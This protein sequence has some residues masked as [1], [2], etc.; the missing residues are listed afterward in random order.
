MNAKHILTI[1]VD[2]KKSR[3][4]VATV[5]KTYSYFYKPFNHIATVKSGGKFVKLFALLYSLPLFLYYMFN[6]G[7]RIVHVHGASNASFWR[8]AFFILVAKCFKKKVVYHIHGGGFK[9]FSQRNRSLVQFV[10]NRCDAII[11]LS[12]YWKD[13]FE[14]ELH[15]KKVYVI[16]NPV[17]MPMEDHSK[18][19][20]EI[21]KFLFLG[22]IHK[23]KGI[24]DLLD[25]ISVQ[26]DKFKGKAKFIIGGFGEVERLK[27]Q[28]TDCK[29]NDLVDYQGWIE[30]DKK[31]KL[32][33]DS[34]VFILPSYIEGVP[35]CILE[36]E[37]YHLPII[38]TKVGGV[39]SIVEHGINGYLLNPGDKDSLLEAIVEMIDNKE[40]RNS[41]GENSYAFAEPHLVEFVE[42]QLEDLYDVLL[43]EK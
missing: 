11:A 24:Y 38:A 4:G 31:I 36:A 40:R 37:T 6:T 30:G 22:K 12:D 9:E 42:Q 34:H 23:S 29:I 41:M 33:N 14:R 26:K 16:L 27:Q 2:Y 3:G 43:N 20:N 39:P 17:Q 1:G 21:V 15:A 7:I 13:Y 5:E 10:I 28:V 35:I 8:K 32:L 19:D 18:R 25:V